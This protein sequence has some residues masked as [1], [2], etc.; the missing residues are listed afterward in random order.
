MWQV[1][2]SRLNAGSKFALPGRSAYRLF[3]HSEYV[4]S[5]GKPPTDLPST[6]LIVRRLVT[7][8]HVLQNSP[9]VVSTCRYPACFGDS[10]GSASSGRLKTP[11]RYGSGSAAR[12]GDRSGP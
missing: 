4:R 3:A 11:E 8:W 7:S 5:I 2:Q 12:S 9:R 1:W 6:F 10:I